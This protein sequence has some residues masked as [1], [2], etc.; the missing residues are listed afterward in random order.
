[1]EGAGLNA[2]TWPGLGNCFMRLTFPYVAGQLFLRAPQRLP[3]HPR[4][5]DGENSYPELGNTDGAGRW[6]EGKRKGQEE[7]GLHRGEASR[8]LVLQEWSL[9]QQ[10]QHGPGASSES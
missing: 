7:A 1:M 3:W 10:Q 5:G 9:N 4:G 8:N 2:Q 6:S